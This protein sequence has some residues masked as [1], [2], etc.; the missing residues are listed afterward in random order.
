MTPDEA[1][2]IGLSISEASLH[3]FGPIARPRFCTA[4]GAVAVKRPNI[5]G[6]LPNEQTCLISQ[7]ALCHDWHR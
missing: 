1:A 3:E 7:L 2:N 5:N 4:N 6:A